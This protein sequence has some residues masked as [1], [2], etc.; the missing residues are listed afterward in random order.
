[1]RKST[2]RFQRLVRCREHPGF[3]RLDSQSR[4]SRRSSTLVPKQLVV[5]PI[6]AGAA[7]RS[8]S[9]LGA[10]FQVRRVC[11]VGAA[12]TIASEDAVLTRNCWDACWDEN[13]AIRI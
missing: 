5:G 10:W 1:M 12:D 8:P 13:A 7:W 6:K 11:R 3:R 2:T 4:V 9:Q